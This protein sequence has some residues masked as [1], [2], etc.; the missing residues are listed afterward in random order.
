MSDKQPEDWRVAW[1]HSFSTTA[2]LAAIVAIVWIL[3]AFS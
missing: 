2:F 3:K 1:A